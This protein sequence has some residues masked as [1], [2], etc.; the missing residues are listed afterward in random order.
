MK[1]KIGS[2]LFNNRKFI[3]NLQK[4]KKYSIKFFYFNFQNFVLMFYNKIK[5]TFLKEFSK[6]F[7]Y[8]LILL[9]SYYQKILN[10]NLIKYPIRKFKLVN[11]FDHLLFIVQY[12]VVRLK[13][14][15]TFNERQLLQVKF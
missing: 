9:L 10:N 1:I 13:Q 4:L 3:K 14:N 6:R 5:T 2:F 12:T 7:L 15:K 8:V 11:L